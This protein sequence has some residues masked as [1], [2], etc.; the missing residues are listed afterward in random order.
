[1]AM[2]FRKPKQDDREVVALPSARTVAKIRGE[3]AE[4]VNLPE[5]V[6]SAMDRGDFGEA[7]RRSTLAA[8]APRRRQQLD[9]ELV[10][11]QEAEVA[12]LIPGLRA[13]LGASDAAVIDVLADV[14]EA[15][16]RLR[17]VK[18]RRNVDS[19]ALSRALAPSRRRLQIE[20]RLQRTPRPA[21]PVGTWR[22]S[23]HG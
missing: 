2:T 13:A 12:P 3:L 4:L 8:H 18:E 11:A 23:D 17:A 1:M 15:M 19:V 20:R 22:T 6:A 14:A 9:L 10:K 5:A 21:A 7:N 16:L